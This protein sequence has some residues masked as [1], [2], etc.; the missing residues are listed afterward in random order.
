MA[1]RPL[2]K[3]QDL[4]RT[5][6]FYSEKLRFTVSESDE[7][8]CVLQMGRGTLSFTT[9][10]L[11][12]GEP[13][14]TGTL[15]IFVDDVVAYYASVHTSVTVIWPLQTRC[16]DSKEFGVLDC[17]GYTLAFAQRSRA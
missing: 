17:N 3:V 9:V 10:D 14:M 1:I 5:K 7:S 13:Q 11:W 16:D 4:E 12:P 15:Y 8:T 6:A 2:L